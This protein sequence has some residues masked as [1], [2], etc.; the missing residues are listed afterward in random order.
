MQSHF[1]LVQFF[2]FLWTVKCQALLS[3]RFSMQEYRSGLPCPPS[4]NLPDPGIEHMSL[5][6]PAL[7]GRVLATST[8][9]KSVCVC[10]CVFSCVQFFATSW[11]SLSVSPVHVISQARILEWVAISSSRGSSPPMDQTPLFL[12]WQSDSLPLGP[13]GK[14]QRSLADYSP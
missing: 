7:A 11:S 9:Y 3:M 2:V 5:M 8:F 10:V 4:E 1:N 12:H 6:S 13:P 14:L